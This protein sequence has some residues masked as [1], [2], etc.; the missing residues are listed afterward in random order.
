MNI[1]PEWTRIGTQN[2][3]IIQKYQ[4][5]LPVKLGAL[6]SE[7]GLIVKKA[8]LPANISGEIKEVNGQVIIRINR[9]DAN[10]RQRYTLAHEIAHFLLHKHLLK[11]GIADDVLY[12]SALSNE[13][14]AEANRLAADIVMPL[15][16]VRDLWK[17]HNPDAPNKEI[18]YERIADELGVSVIAL[19]IRLE[20]I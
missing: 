2:Q 16:A 11:D 17:K 7:L 19:K 18:T 4:N 14:E 20:K 13:I 10:S 6:A 9:H 15:D 1:S 12:R 5:E 3:N 8:T